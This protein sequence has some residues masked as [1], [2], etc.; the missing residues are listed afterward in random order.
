MQQEKQWFYQ[1][2]VGVPAFWDDYVHSGLTIV[3][4]WTLV[5]PYTPFNPP[6]DKVPVYDN[7]IPEVVRTNKTVGED[8]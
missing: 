4:S 6:P 7:K 1:L 2:A 5:P 8:G 3:S